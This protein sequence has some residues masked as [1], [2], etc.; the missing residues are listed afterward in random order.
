[1]MKGQ[2]AS[3]PFFFPLAGC[4]IFV[5][6]VGFRAFSYAQEVNDVWKHLLFLCPDYA[7]GCHTR[8]EK[9]A[10]YASYITEII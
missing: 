2:P 4:S 5:P 10:G 3:C 6:V 1:M 8:Y 7:P 9:T